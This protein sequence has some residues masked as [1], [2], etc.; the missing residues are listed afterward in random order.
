MIP[1]AAKYRT[2]YFSNFLASF[3]SIFVNI[4]KELVTFE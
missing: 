3:A 2:Q 1:P 4:E